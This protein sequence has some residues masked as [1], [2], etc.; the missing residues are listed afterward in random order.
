MPTL[1]NGKFT[2][3]KRGDNKQEVLGRTNSLLFF[4]MTRIAQKT[5][6]IRGAKIER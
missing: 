2:S 3:L 1:P 4:D 5:K 6:K